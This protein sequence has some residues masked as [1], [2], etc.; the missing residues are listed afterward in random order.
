MVDQDGFAEQVSGVA[1]L[2]EPVR[3][4]LYL[5]VVAAPGPV[6]RDAAS[7]GVGVPRHTAKFHLDRLVE[8]GLLDVEFRRLSGREGPGAGRPAKLYRRSGRELSVALPARHYDLAGQLLASAIDASTHDGSDILAALDRSATEAG[9]EIARTAG[10]AKDADRADG[11]AATRRVLA[12]NGYEPHTVGGT[13]TLGNC[14]FDA[15]A[16]DHTALVCGMNLALVGAVTEALAPGELVTAL[17]P[18]PGRCCVILT[19]SASAVDT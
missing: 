17:E 12:A 8:Q 4:E 14:P 18:A 16:R 15:L 1:A 2:A 7:E 3:R 5:F 6:S 9:S 11:R 19:E 13:T 10:D